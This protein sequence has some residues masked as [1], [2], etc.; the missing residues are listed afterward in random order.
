LIVLAT[1]SSGC[2]TFLS[3]PGFANKTLREGVDELIQML[4][5]Q[6]ITDAFSR[7][8]ARMNLERYIQD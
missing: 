3:A 8:A 7:P 4:E 5:I 1:S 2:A 6:G